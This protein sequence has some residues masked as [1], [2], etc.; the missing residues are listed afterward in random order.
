MFKMDNTAFLNVLSA[1]HEYG[2]V[3]NYRA[4]ADGTNAAMNLKSIGWG[5]SPGGWQE[6]T[7]PYSNPPLQ[8]Q[9]IG[10]YLDLYKNGDMVAQLTL[11]VTTDGTATMNN[12]NIWGWGISEGTSQ[13]GSA[14]T[15]YGGGNRTV[16][17]TGTGTYT[18]TGS[19]ENVLNFN[20]FN[21]P[22]G[23][24]ASVILNFLNGLNGTYTMEAH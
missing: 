19:G 3:G 7:N 12:S 5:A 10:K 8:G 11:L 6:A 15:N 16:T 14:F 17:S 1:N 23:G 21:M 9:V 24:N 2:L 13:S 20:G 4:I 22:A 18:Q